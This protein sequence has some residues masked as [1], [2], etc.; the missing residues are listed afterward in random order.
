MH[1]SPSYFSAPPISGGE[2]AVDHSLQF[3][4]FLLALTRAWTEALLLPPVSTLRNIPKMPI[5]LD[6]RLD[7]GL[8]ALCHNAATRHTIAVECPRLEPNVSDGH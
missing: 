6:D 1:I 2:I 5:S 8:H 4:I 7:G 3:R